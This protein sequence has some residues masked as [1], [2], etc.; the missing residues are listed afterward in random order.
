VLPDGRPGRFDQ[1]LAAGVAAEAE[2]QEVEPLREVDDVRL[3]LVQ[4]QP[5]GG[6]P[7]GKP[8]PDLLGLL[9]G[10]AADDEVIGVSDQDRGA[11]FG[12][13]G[14]RAGGVVPGPGGLLKAVQR[15]VQQDG[16]D[17]AAL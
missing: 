12:L 3:V 15:D 8:R 7:S 13:P 5:P 1:Q 11:L 6:Q 16:A 2:P 9:P 4:G 17:D 10:V 14:F